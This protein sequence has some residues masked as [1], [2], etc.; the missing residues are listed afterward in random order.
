[1][2]QTRLLVFAITLAMVAP[3]TRDAIALTEDDAPLNFVFLFADDQT[4]RSVG[5]LNNPE[6]HT[7]N[8]DRM[9]S[10]GTTFENAINQGGWHGALCVASRAMLMSGRH[11]HQT[12]GTAEGHPLLGETLQAAG[13][14]TIGIGKWHNSKASYA[15]S[16]TDGA[17]IFF[18]GMSFPDKGGQWAPS[19]QPFDP[20]GVFPGTDRAQI[21]TH[22]SELFSTAAI[23]FIDAKSA[24][25]T[26]R[27][28][29]LYVSY[30]TP[31]DPRQAPEEFC[32]MHPPDQLTLPPN[33][34]PEHPF[35]Q[36]DAKVRD[37]K[38]AAFP[39][40]PEE[41]RQH[42]SDYYATISH[43]DAQ[44]GRILDAV[45]ASPLAKNT[46]VV[47]TADHGLAVGQH[48]LLGKQNLYDH[49]IRVPMIIRGPGIKAG[50]KIPGQVYIHCLNATIC[51]LAGVEHPD[52]VQAQSLVPMLE[53]PTLDLFPTIYASYRNLQRTVRT[54]DWKL[55]V[56]PQVEVRQ[57]FHIA[58]DPWEQVNLAENPA[59]AARMRR[60][61]DDL[62]GWMART[63]D[64][65][66]LDESLMTPADP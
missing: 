56:Y 9:V 62:K 36:G 54:R 17:H 16:F 40:T 47:F 65:F 29:F 46:I 8:L 13:Y 3:L 48:G 1:M 60:M 41:V 38:L 12:D 34:V 30:L 53:D 5:A 25:E 35:D 27:P 49:S 4:F 52:S 19:V 22:S 37:E 45:D 33:F 57:L 14:D 63:G 26:P 7:P 2:H 55:I 42:I 23:D 31:H 20:E 15:R 51:E 10:E 58:E 61:F 43:L 64:G 44:V 21:H 32:A 66:E 18:G 6:I 59:H 39:R 28:F 24:Q 50:Q 11:L